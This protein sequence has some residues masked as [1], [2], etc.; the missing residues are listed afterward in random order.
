MSAKSGAANNT[1]LC[2]SIFN[3]L[4]LLTLRTGNFQPGVVEH[5]FNPSTWEAVA[6]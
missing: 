6:G 3:S 1:W 4:I 2:K 5:A